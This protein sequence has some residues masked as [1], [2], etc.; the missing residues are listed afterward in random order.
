MT[1]CVPLAD[2]V[3]A[4]KDHRTGPMLSCLVDHDAVNTQFACL[5][6]E[7]DMETVRVV[8]AAAPNLAVVSS[9]VLHAEGTACDA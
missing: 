7:G 4:L 8:G 1:P 3:S 6:D 5:C 9:C 2:L